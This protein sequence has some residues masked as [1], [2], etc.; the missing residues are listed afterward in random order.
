M[1]SIH[2]IRHCT[3]LY[4]NLLV[5]RRRAIVAVDAN[6]INPKPRACIAVPKDSLD[7]SPFQTFL[8]NP[9]PFI[10]RVKKRTRAHL[11][12]RR[13]E[14]RGLQRWS[15]RLG[16]L[17]P[18]RFARG[19]ARRAPLLSLAHR[20]PPGGQRGAQVVFLQTPWAGEGRLDGVCLP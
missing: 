9:K 13:A 1:I 6:I 18:R 19:W 14:I 4:T 10:A 11:L 17:P 15:R 20:A 7:A 8:P 3:H 2:R 16:A 5:N 12:V